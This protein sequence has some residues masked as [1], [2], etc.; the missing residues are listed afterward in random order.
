MGVFLIILLLIIGISGW[1]SYQYY[2]TT[3]NEILS[4]LVELD[5]IFENRFN[6]LTKAISQ[7]QKYMPEQ[8][9]LIYDIQLSKADVAKISKPKTTKELA[10]K[11]MNEN[12]LNINLKFF[13]D[14]C[15]L[16]KIDP[17]LKIHV[18]KQIDY[19]KKISETAVIYN[20]LMTNYNS[21]KNIFPFTYYAKMK[22]IDLD[23]DLIKTE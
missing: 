22:G 6:D 7:F 3:V 20:K 11:I 10:Q 1:L 8:Q 2:K 19:I 9:N 4:Q 12:S 17:E 21:I 5:K 23:M 16:E 18:Q 13:L 15:D 14:K